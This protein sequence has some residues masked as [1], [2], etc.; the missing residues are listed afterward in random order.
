MTLTEGGLDF[1]AIRDKKL[2]A[3]IGIEPI[4]VDLN[5]QSGA[6]DHSPTATK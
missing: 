6:F 4:T 2:Q 1:F 5:S 3:W